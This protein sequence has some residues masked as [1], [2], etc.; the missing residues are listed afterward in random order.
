MEAQ[1]PTPAGSAFH[2]RSNG[3]GRQVSSLRWF[4]GSALVS[5]LV[6][7]GGG[8][9]GG[10]GSAEVNKA[11]GALTTP[12][13]SQSIELQARGAVLNTQDSADAQ[14]EA[15]SLPANTPLAELAEGQTAP[16]AA[17]QSGLVARKAAAALVPVY[18]FYNTQ[19]GTHFYT[20]S[21]S[22]R[23]AVR[24][25]QPIYSYEG[26]AFM[27]ASAASVGL[28]P[29]YR[30]FNTQ[31]GVHFYTI[32]ESERFNIETTMPQFQLEGVAYYASQV[33]GI[34]FTPLY[35][36]FLS[37]AGTHFYTVS[38][39]ERQRVI[40][41]LSSTYSFEG[42]GYQVLTGACSFVNTT[43]QQATPNGCYLANNAAQVNIAL[44][45]SACHRTSTSA[46]RVTSAYCSG[47]DRQPSS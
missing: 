7:C 31:T 5:T 4:F 28:K 8:G 30:F 45:S 17:Y 36:F 24:A 47:I 40:D 27:A 44:P 37:G 46:G 32:S 39:A 13:P 23:D 42:V 20:S 26:Q 19:T 34:G 22:E 35:R 15:Q 1:S 14:A 38:E 10:D 16:L 2:G 21:A 25:S 6:A 41:T 12:S 43:A 33:A 18:R 3:W 29:V 9:S 11:L